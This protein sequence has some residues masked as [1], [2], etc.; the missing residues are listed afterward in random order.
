MLRYHYI[1]VGAVMLFVGIA[2]LPL[3]VNPGW[4]N[5][6]RPPVWVAWFTGIMLISGLGWLLV[7]SLSTDKKEPEIEQLDPW[8]MQRFVMGLSDQH[9]PSK[10]RPILTSTSL[11]YFGLL[12]E[13]AG[14]QAKTMA[15]II[16]RGC[17]LDDPDF[18]F[19][20]DV[21]QLEDLASILGVSSD[22][23]KKTAIKMGDQVIELTRPEAVALL[24]DNIDVTVVT[25]GF[26]EATGLPGK[27]G[28]VEV[29]LSNAS[30]ADPETG[31][32]KKEPS[33]KWI[34]GPN[35]RQPN[36]ASS[37]DV[38]AWEAEAEVLYNN[39]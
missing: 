4:F 22:R 33:G 5:L 6:Q 9:L 13:E 18:Y 36:L 35:Y 14:E 3:T 10:A 11:L 30:K 37:L 25:L 19:G 15:G 20:P 38:A 24:D 12:M 21:S 7:A 2:Y 28:Y 17:V 32:I 39:I 31:K 29:Q 27:G 34:K 1:L 26:A 16:K 8:S 23:L